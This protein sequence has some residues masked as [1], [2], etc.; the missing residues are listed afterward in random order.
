[1]LKIGTTQAVY[2]DKYGFREGLE[3]M[4]THGFDS[5]DYQEFI[6][7]ATPLF[8]KST[9]QFEAYLKEERKI[10]EAVGIG[11]HQ[12]HGPWRYPPQDAN[13]ADREERFEKMVRSMEGTAILG[14]DRMVLH[15]LMPFSRNDQG[16]EKES[17][18]MNLEF[19][20]RIC[21]AAKE[22]GII[23]CFENMPMPEL[24]L[25]SVPAVVD[26]VKTINSDHFKICLDTGHSNMFSYS[27]GDCVRMIGKEY[28]YALHIHDN[29]GVRDRHWSP[30]SGIVDWQD[31]GKALAE[32]RYEGVISLETKVSNAIPDELREYEEIGLYKKAKYISELASHF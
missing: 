8:E 14:C 1:M 27:A 12:T 29:D 15:S 11:V 18:E 3:R 10:L 25:G 26:F 30:F 16:H 9:S 4:K 13:V 21:E 32:I 28:L 2:C 22:R 19:M 23:I 5:M 31:F 6:E 7:T 20:G 24:S 17:Y